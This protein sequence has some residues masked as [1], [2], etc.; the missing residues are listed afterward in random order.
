MQI[1]DRERSLPSP[2][3]RRVVVGL[4]LAALASLAL[5]ATGCGGSSGD[6]VAQ[7]D[8]PETTTTQAGSSDGS[9][10]DDPAAFS[11]CMRKNG[12]PNFP[13]PDSKGHI[14]ITGGKT[15]NGR[16]F[17]FDPNSPQF[18][19]AQQA[20]RRFQPNGGKPDPQQVAKDQ[21]E[22]LKFSQCMR[23]HGVPK[24]P[25][26]TS[27]PNGGSL[28]TID[29]DLNPDSPQF[30]EAEKACQTQLPGGGMSSSGPMA[31]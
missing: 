14:R 23:S 29:K 1:V 17:G 16:K 21:Q 27:Q 6:G 15:A 4:A 2:A 13:D 25:D 3:P 18:R 28:L 12:V 30:K 19:K 9:S 26:P 7:A 31:Q 10:S 24:F 8:S 5:L 11:A 22:A 20:C